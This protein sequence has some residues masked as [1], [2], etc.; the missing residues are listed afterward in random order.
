LGADG[1]KRKPNVFRPAIADQSLWISNGEPG[2]VFD[3]VFAA[4]EKT[5]APAERTAVCQPS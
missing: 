1:A 3:T 4:W 5:R 2:R